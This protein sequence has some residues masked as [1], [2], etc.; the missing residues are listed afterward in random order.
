MAFSADGKDIV[1]A[2]IDSGID[3]NHDHFKPFSN[4]TLALPLE[5]KDFT[6]SGNSPLT[7][8]F[9]HGTHVAGIIAGMMDETS[10][11]QA[12]IRTRDEESGNIASVIRPLGRPIRGMAPQCKLISMKVLDDDVPWIATVSCSPALVFTSA[13]TW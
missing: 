2:V 10:A 9:G 5:H 12:I 6:S 7:D 8:E 11:P 1:W 4:L 3:R 13:V